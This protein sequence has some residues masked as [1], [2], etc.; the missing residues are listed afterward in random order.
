MQT[1]FTI[2]VLAAFASAKAPSFQDAAYLASTRQ[3]KANLIWGQ[4]IATTKPYGWYSA[5]A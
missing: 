4:V 2:A 3:S 5:V 1:K